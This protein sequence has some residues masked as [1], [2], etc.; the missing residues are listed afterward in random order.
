[1][2]S[3]NND[4]ARALAGVRLAQRDYLTHLG[5]VELYFVVSA[6]ENARKAGASEAEIATALERASVRGAA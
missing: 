1:V 4:I 6:K 2:S 5:P 3:P